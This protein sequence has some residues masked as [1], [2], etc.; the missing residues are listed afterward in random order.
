MGPLE[1]TTLNQSINQSS[2]Q[3]TVLSPFQNT[4]QWAKTRKQVLLIVIYHHQKLLE[5]IYKN[6]ILSTKDFKHILSVLTNMCH[7]FSLAPSKEQKRM[8]TPK[9]PWPPQVVL[10]IIVTSRTD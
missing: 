6:F 1:R 7:T 9:R 3:N 5:L 4:R 10:G 8:L 2:S